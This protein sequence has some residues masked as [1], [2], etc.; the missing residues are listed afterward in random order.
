MHARH[1]EHFLKLNTTVSNAVLHI[2]HLYTIHV[3]PYK[4]QNAHR[5]YYKL[6]NMLFEGVA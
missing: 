2:L 1:L 4:L 5:F 6:E 3:V